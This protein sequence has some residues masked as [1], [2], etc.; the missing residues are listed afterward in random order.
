[1]CAM[2]RASAAEKGVVVFAINQCYLRSPN[3][4]YRGLV[5]PRVNE[6][7]WLDIKGRGSHFNVAPSAQAH[8]RMDYRVHLI[9]MSSN[10][11]RGQFR[12]KVIEPVSGFRKKYLAGFE[13]GGNHIGATLLTTPS[14]HRD[15][16]QRGIPA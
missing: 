16:G 12:D 5:R 15:D 4:K 14:F 6:G 9:V 13:E 3:I 8:E 1:M 10:R 2:R 11:E 7:G